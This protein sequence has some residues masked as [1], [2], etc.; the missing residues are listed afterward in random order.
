MRVVFFGGGGWGGWG[1]EGGFNVPPLHSENFQKILTPA[2]PK[3]FSSPLLCPFIYSQA[4]VCFSPF[5]LQNCLLKCNSVLRMLNSIL[6][7]IF[8]QSLVGTQEN[9]AQYTFVYFRLPEIDL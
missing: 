3:N 4:H 5:V 8:L 9:F 1:V 7:N 6:G 2:L